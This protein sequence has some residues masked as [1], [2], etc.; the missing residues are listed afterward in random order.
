MTLEHDFG[1]L[2]LVTSGV[3]VWKDVSFKAERGCLQ[4]LYKA[5]N[6]VLG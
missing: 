4:V 3:T 6:S 1:W 2:R 5:S